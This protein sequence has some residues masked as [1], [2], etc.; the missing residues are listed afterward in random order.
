MWLQQSRPTVSTCVYQAMDTPRLLNQQ[1]AGAELDRL[2]C[3]STRSLPLIDRIQRH[4][5]GEAGAPASQREREPSDTKMRQSRH[6]IV[7]CSLVSKGPRRDLCQPSRAPGGSF[8]SSR[9]CCSRRPRSL[10]IGTEKEVCLRWM[11][12]P[13]GSGEPLSQRS[14]WKARS[15]STVTM[16]SAA[17]KSS[18]VSTK[19]TGSCSTCSARLRVQRSVA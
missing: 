18:L 10:W 9:Q 5:N 16:D 7:S 14:A 15:A 19:M 13:A 6:E 12:R 2:N 11:Q 8:D 17:S 4:G 3:W 1:W